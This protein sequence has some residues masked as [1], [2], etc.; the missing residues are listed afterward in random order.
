MNCVQLQPIPNEDRETFLKEAYMREVKK[1]VVEKQNSMIRFPD[2]A[3]KSGQHTAYLNIAKRL[4]SFEYIHNGIKHM[5][6]LEQKMFGL[7]KDVAFLVEE[8]KDSGLYH[9]EAVW[10]GMARRVPDERGIVFEPSK[11][12]SELDPIKDC[13]PQELVML[14][15]KYQQGKAS[16]HEEKYEY[17]NV[18][19]GKITKP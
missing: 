9:E 3:I 15:T 16:F 1:W 7:G 11:M 8:F 18:F 5:S 6:E 12:L 2:Q 14:Y 17:G 10:L 19:E 4:L 13:S